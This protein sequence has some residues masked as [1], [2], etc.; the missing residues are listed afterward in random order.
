MR[1]TDFSGAGTIGSTARRTASVP[2]YCV[3]RRRVAASCSTAMATSM[4]SAGA[5]IIATRPSITDSNSGFFASSA[6]GPGRTVSVSGMRNSGPRERKAAAT[7]VK[8]S[9]FTA[10]RSHIRTTIAKA[11]RTS[12]QP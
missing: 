3:D 8:A 7:A 12:G 1:S 2:K 11:R 4:P 10:V 5:Q 6:H 9:A